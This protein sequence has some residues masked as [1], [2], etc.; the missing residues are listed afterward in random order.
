MKESCLKKLKSD[1][2]VGVVVQKVKLPV[3]KLLSHIRALLHIPAIPPLSWSLLMLLEAAGD[4]SSTLK[5][6]QGDLA[7]AP[8]SWVLPDTAPAVVA[9]A[10]EVDFCL[11]FCFSPTPAF[12]I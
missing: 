3:G 8:G 1:P 11:F 10:W 5:C 12:Q 6:L 7:R 9:C 2:E 4:G